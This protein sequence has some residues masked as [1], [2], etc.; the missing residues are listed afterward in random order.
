L[1]AIDRLT[2]MRTLYA[3]VRQSQ[4]HRSDRPVWFDVASAVSENG[5]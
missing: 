2:E 1:G 5:S 4:E 3:Q